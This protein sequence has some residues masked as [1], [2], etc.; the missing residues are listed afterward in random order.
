MTSTQA[1]A[2]AGAGSAESAKNKPSLLFFYS[3]TSGASRRVDG[4]LAQVLQRRA[5][6]ST[7]RLL[8]IDADSRPDLLE[9]FAVTDIPTLLVAAEGHV[10]GRLA[11]PTGSRQI[12]QF[13]TPWLR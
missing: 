11:N 7:F 3:T 12:H 5:N 2:A 4:F 6:H 8:R 10:R 1:G 13:L 9:R